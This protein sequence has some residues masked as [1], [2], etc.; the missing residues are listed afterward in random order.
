MHQNKFFLKKPI[1]LKGETDKPIIIVGGFNIPL[2]A[3]TRTT[4]Q[5]ISKDREKHNTIS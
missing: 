3:I 4:K 2:S 5:K 1:K